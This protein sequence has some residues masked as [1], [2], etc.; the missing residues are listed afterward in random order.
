MP[1][2]NQSAS[3]ADATPPPARIETPAINPPWHRSPAWA[4]AF[5]LL[6]HVLILHI[7]RQSPPAAE[8]PA[9]ISA[10]LAAPAPTPKPRQTETKPSKSAS[11][12]VKPSR[13]IIAVDK[14]KTRPTAEPNRQW[15]VAEKAEMDN[16]LNELATPARPAP[17]LAQRSLAM[18]RE[19]G[20]EQGQRDGAAEDT[21][22]R[23]P[24]SPPVDPFSLEMYLDAV[25]KKLNRSAGFVRNDPRTRG[26][27]NAL[28]RVQLKPD[29]SLRRFEIINSA[30]Q[31]DEIAF[32][33]SVVEQAVPFAAFPPDLLRSAMSLGMFIC[34]RP[35]SSSSAGGFSRGGEGSRC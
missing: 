16:F 28:V 10:S 26:M 5:S 33:K 14:S 9:R 4:I 1:D 11:S 18:A 19:Y 21:V 27:R 13:N 15:S 20:R 22:E 25:V 31:Q 8:P 29:G 6:L 35:P 23:R 7:P 24:N 12:K 17:T 3:A 34:I 2:L 32:V 30:D